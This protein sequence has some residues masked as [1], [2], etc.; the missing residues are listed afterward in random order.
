MGNVISISS[1]ENQMLMTISDVSKI[2]GVTT[3]TLRKWDKSGKL[4]PVRTIG[5]HRRYLK[6]DVDR[7]FTGM[8]DG[9]VKVIELLGEALMY[10]RDESIRQRIEKIVETLESTMEHRKKKRN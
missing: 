3:Q 8:T 9:N 7:V 1:N 10:T 6:K 4:I 5:G 2:L